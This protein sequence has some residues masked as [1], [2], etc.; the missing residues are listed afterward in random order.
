[1]RRGHAGATQAFPKERA[2]AVRTASGNRH[3]H[4]V[5]LGAPD[6]LAHICARHGPGRG[7]TMLFSRRSLAASGMGRDMYMGCSGGHFFS[8]C[9]KKVPR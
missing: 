5:A 2:G 9:E 3:V 4:A 8:P 7:R 6:E 1:M